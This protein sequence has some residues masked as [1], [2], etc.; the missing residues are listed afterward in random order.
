MIT[1]SVI[2]ERIII[3]ETENKDRSLLAFIHVLAGV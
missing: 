2:R 1:S 3:K